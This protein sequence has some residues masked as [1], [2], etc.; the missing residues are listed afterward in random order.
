MAPR[1]AR[2]GILT[3]VIGTRKRFFAE[4]LRHRK[5]HRHALWNRLARLLCA[6]RTA[7][8]KPLLRA[9]SGAVR[10][11]ESRCARV[12]AGRPRLP[13]SAQ[14]KGRAWQARGK[15]LQRRTTCRTHRRCREPLNTTTASAMSSPARPRQPQERIASGAGEQSAI[16]R[17]RA[18]V[19]ESVDAA[20]SKSAALKSVWVRVPPSAPGLT[21][22]SAAVCFL[23]D[24]HSALT[25]ITG[26]RFIFLSSFV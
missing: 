24:H 3:I 16:L 21:A 5:G 26:K 22:A 8:A 12:A 13:I 23:R 1:A 18:E 20:D 6:G 25:A 11:A 4:R 7:H 17:G 15:G 19:A 14:R 9:A 2:S 10:G